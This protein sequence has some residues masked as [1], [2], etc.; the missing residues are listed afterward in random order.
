[1]KGT[2]NSDD[3]GAGP[4]ARPDLTIESADTIR[5]VGVPPAN[6]DAA[7]EAESPRPT[8][9]ADLDAMRA[10]IQGYIQAAVPE[11][12]ERLKTSDPT[13]SGLYHIL[14]PPP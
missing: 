7:S 13:G 2:E 14:H 9:D 3:V 12:F 6:A 10:R 1:L 11:L 8:G 5:S 4:C